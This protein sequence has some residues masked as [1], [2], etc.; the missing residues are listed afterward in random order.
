MSL[1]RTSDETIKV[2]LGRKKAYKSGPKEAVVSKGFTVTLF[3]YTILM[4]E[5]SVYD[6]SNNSHPIVRKLLWQA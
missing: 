3:F 1:G 5:I 6:Q 4:R 2:N